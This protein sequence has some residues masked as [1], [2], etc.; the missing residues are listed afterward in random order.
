MG[1]F[2]IQKNSVTKIRGLVL[3]GVDESAAGCPNTLSGRAFSELS[4]R[5][6]NK[7]V[8]Y[9]WS[10]GSRRRWTSN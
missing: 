9:A 10:I 6:S 8:R 2:S 4:E 1:S 7:V 3:A 5:L